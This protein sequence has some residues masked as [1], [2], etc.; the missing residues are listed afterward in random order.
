MQKLG[1]S[2]FSREFDEFYKI[3]LNTHF[4]IILKSQKWNYK[5]VHSDFFN[6]TLTQ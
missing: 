3:N 1:H 2:I 5:A 4:T 6:C